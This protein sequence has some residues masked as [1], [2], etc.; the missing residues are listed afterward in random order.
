MD[1]SALVARLL[2]TLVGARFRVQSRSWVIARASVTNTTLSLTF[3]P[4]RMVTIDL[5][6][7][8]DGDAVEHRA[9]LLYNVERQLGTP[10]Q[11]A[12]VA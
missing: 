2:R 4:A 3:E 9:W 10:D 8:F 5:P 11:D 6:E 1:M 7:T 12:D